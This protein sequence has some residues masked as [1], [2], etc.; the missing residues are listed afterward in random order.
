M[1]AS[2]LRKRKFSIVF[3]SRANLLSSISQ[4]INNRSPPPFL[5]STLKVPEWKR[6]ETD[7]TSFRREKEEKEK[8]KLFSVPN[9]IN[10][11]EKSTL[12]AAVK[13]IENSFFTLVFSDVVNKVKLCRIPLSLV[14]PTCLL[15]SWKETSFLGGRIAG[16]N[17]KEKWKRGRD[18]KLAERRL[19]VL[20]SLPFPLGHR[21]KGEKGVYLILNAFPTLSLERERE[22]EG[23]PTVILLVT[24]LI[25][26]FPFYFQ[27]RQT[28]TVQR[29][30][31]F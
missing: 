10:F 26:S 13:E 9:S 6:G 28:T 2:H 20:L 27:V 1:A 12:V 19:T 7:M 31:I 23:K 24:I 16:K 30:K 25:V 3:L 11:F 29:G 5:L 18:S 17:K 22:K 15:Q 21:K 8:P 4:V 14:G